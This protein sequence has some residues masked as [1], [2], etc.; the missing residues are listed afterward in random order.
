MAGGGGG[1]NGAHSKQ[2]KGEV[3]F[4][5]AQSKYPGNATC[6]GREQPS[7]FLIS[8]GP[9]HRAQEAGIPRE[10][11][12]RERSSQDLELDVYRSPRDRGAWGSGLLRP[13]CFSAKGPAFPT[14]L[15]PNTQ[16][17]LWAPF[18]SPKS[19]CLVA[20]T[21]F[22]ENKISHLKNKNKQNS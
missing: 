19:P 13:D 7:L 9:S 8:Q 4:R 16:R 3:V 15:A 10:P 21:P 2:M 22:S 12:L 14:T 11:T 6:R 17:C 5:F 20:L 1:A 18:I